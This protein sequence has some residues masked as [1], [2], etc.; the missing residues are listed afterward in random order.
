MRSGVAR[1]D[2]YV[3]SR[4]TIQ[5]RFYSVA[6]ITSGSDRHQHHVD[7]GHPG[8]PGSIPGKTYGFGLLSGALR[9]IPT[10]SSDFLHIYKNFAFTDGRSMWRL[11]TLNYLYDPDSALRFRSSKRFFESDTDLEGVQRDKVAPISRSL[12]KPGF[13]RE[14]RQNQ[15]GSQGL[16]RI[17]VPRTRTRERKC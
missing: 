9:S 2:N 12:R 8:D 7:V 3:R 14:T 4:Q 6:V 13:T 10:T 17:Q 15:K 16:S 5:K 11:M 1:Q